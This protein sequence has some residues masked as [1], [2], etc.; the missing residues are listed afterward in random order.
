MSNIFT[1]LKKDIENKFEGGRRNRNVN[2]SAFHIRDAR[3]PSRLYYTY[4]P[5]YVLF[6]PP[7]VYSTGTARRLRVFVPVDAHDQWLAQSLGDS[8]FGTIEKRMSKVSSKN[9]F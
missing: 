1:T 3:S 4:L 9:I 2:Y 8:T 5:F 7:F 6:H